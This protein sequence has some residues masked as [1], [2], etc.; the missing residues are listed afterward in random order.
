LNPNDIANAKSSVIKLSITFIAL[1]VVTWILTNYT[2]QI[3]TTT[4]TNETLPMF[5]IYAQS[6]TTIINGIA[7]ATSIALGFGVTFVGIIAREILTET[8]NQGTKRYLIGTYLLVFPILLIQL[9][10]AYIF[11]LIGGIFLKTALAFAFIGLIFAILSITAIFVFLEPIIKEQNEEDI[12]PQLPSPPPLNNQ[13]N[14]ENQIETK[15]T[16]RDG[17]KTVNITINM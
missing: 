8:K 5:H 2:V 14:K 4:P 6:V 9:A 7:T 17:N 1:A 12:N 11:L 10:T 16:S 3:D 15:T 13:E